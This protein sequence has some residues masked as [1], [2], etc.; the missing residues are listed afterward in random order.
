MTPRPLC[1][2]PDPILRE[3]AR[4]VPAMTDEIR[5]L[6]ADMAETMQA[7]DGL[8]LAA[9]QIG[10][11]LRVI[12]MQC[13]DDPTPTTSYTYTPSDSLGE[14]HPDGLGESHADM[15]GESHPDMLGESD[16]DWLAVP[17]DP[18][19][20]THPP[21]LWKMANPRIIEKSTETITWEEGCLS[22]PDV[23][24]KVTRPE[25]VRVRYLAEHGQEE[26]MEAEGLLAVCVQHE[27]DHLNGRLFIDYLSAAK[28][29]MIIRKFEKQARHAQTSLS[30]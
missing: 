29:D 15:L 23:K 16:A 19:P 2:L 21:K 1:I 28:R 10:E 26:E 8:G 25:W 22:I 24:G 9:P 5:T 30:A 11:K 14:S 6:M 20:A 12:V 17:A 18:S 13:P 3:T 4:P 27:I 7:A